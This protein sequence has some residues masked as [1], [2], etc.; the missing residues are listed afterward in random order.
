MQSADAQ[1]LQR[2]HSL[3]A[4]KNKVL[5]RNIPVMQLG[6]ILIKIV[7]SRVRYHQGVIAYRSPGVRSWGAKTPGLACWRGAFAKP[8]SQ[9]TTAAGP[10]GI[11]G[12]QYAA[13]AQSL[14]QVCC[15]CWC[16]VYVGGF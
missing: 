16:N 12:P 8:G 2:F 5:Q 10:Q 14:M 15:C 11:D 1:H 13:H 3:C 9:V 4:H 6:V 7:A